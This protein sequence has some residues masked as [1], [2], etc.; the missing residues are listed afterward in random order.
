[1]YIAVHLLFTGVCS[2]VYWCVCLSLV[3]F[4][5]T[6]CIALHIDLFFKVPAHCLLLFRFF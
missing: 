2:P 3:L 6:R 1:M 4:Q 5:H